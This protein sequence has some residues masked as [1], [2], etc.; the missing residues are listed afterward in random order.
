MPEP[1][2]AA[3]S[4]KA[5]EDIR[6]ALCGL[7][8]SFLTAL[9]L[10][11]VEERFGFA[12]YTWMFWSIIPVGAL[13]SGFAGASGYCA[14]SVCFGH[15]PTRLLL[16]NIVVASLATFF[17]INYLS[18]ITLQ[19]EGKRVSDYMPFWSYLDI[20]IRSTTMVFRYGVVVEAVKFGSTEELG[21]FGYVVSLLQILG[22]TA[23]GFSY[24]AYLVSQPYCEKC[25]RYLSRKGKQVRYT[26]DGGGL[27]AATAR[28][29]E[30]LKSDAI[31]SAI[32]QYKEFGTPQ[33]QKENHLRSVVEVRYCKKCSKH[34][35]KFFV[36]KKSGD[37]WKEISELT[38]AGF[39]QQVVNI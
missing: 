39:T 20:A 38:V 26:G 8:T 1:G 25:S 15:R 16:L 29:F 30:F 10:W 12:L 9:I 27:Q 28:V 14:G 22:F 4:R 31:A 13:L 24:Y 34:W 35:V 6:V 17:L 33:H 2:L 5:G 19:V 11:F 21:S 7:V 36:E 18:Y 23:G 37:N 32:Q 3:D